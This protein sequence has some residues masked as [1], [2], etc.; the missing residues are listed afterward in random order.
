MEGQGPD[1]P[2]CK[3]HFQNNITNHSFRQYIYIYHALHLL[4]VWQPVGPPCPLFYYTFLLGLDCPMN[5][6]WVSSFK[7]HLILIQSVFTI[8]PVRTY[9][10]FLQSPSCWDNFSYVLS[11]IGTFTTH[12][13][14]YDIVIIILLGLS[15]AN[16]VSVVVTSCTVIFIPIPAEH[17]IWI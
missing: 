13:S 17:S 9:L 7:F 1:P 6:C 15:S 16:H 4:L 8:H 3:L 12:S 2:H 14:F 10:T 5:T 11:S